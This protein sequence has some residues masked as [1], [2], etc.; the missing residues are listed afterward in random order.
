MKLRNKVAGGVVAVGM[1]V[2]GSLFAS[3]ASAASPALK[4]TDAYVT[5]DFGTPGLLEVGDSFTLVFDKA[6]QVQGPSFGI[7]VADADGDR[8]YLGDQGPEIRWSIENLVTYNKKGRASISYDR[9][10][11]VTIVELW[12]TVPGLD[13]PTTITEISGVYPASAGA[14]GGGLVNVA[15]SADKVIDAE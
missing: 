5:G 4:I 14:L 15:R 2:T 10:L 12:G 8:V 13:L 6:I 9:V 11:A 1:A 3:P 7:T